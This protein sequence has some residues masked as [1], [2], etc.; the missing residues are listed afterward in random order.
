MQQKLEK[1]GILF[2][3]LFWPIVERWISDWE[4]LLQRFETKLGKEFAMTVE[5]IFFFNNGSA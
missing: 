5:D 4:K 2:R 3:K 1:T